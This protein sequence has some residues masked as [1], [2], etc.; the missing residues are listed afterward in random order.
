V[1]KSSKH[2]LLSDKRVLRYIMPDIAVKKFRKA[3]SSPQVLAGL[4]TMAKMGLEFLHSDRK[5]KVGV[6]HYRG[7][8]H[9]RSLFEKSMYCNAE[10]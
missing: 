2:K 8:L 7:E 6:I 4:Q 5:F 10:F 3:K 9:E 1:R